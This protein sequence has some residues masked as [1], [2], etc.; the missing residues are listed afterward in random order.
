LVWFGA[1]VGV[2]ASERP[3]LFEVCAPCFYSVRPW[4]GNC[5]KK[6]KGFVPRFVYMSL[7]VP[8]YVSRYTK[9]CIF[10]VVRGHAESGKAKDTR[11]TFDVWFTIFVALDRVCLGATIIK[12][13]AS[14]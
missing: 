10:I 1:A 4:L 8:M 3:A 6:R 5:L 11:V 12:C 14:N 13:H 7:L 9:H 2:G